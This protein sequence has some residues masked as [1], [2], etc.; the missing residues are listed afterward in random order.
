MLTNQIKVYFSY[1]GAKEAGSALYKGVKELACLKFE[2]CNTDWR[3]GNYTLLEELL[4]KH[5][6]GQHL[7]RDLVVSTLANQNRVFL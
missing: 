3:P 6:V 2:C 7:A 4:D 1:I 5:L